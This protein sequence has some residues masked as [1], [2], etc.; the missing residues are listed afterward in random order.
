MRKRLLA[1]VLALAMATTL[2]P[3]SVF[4]VDAETDESPMHFTKTVTPIDR[5]DGKYTV[6]MEAYATGAVTTE[7]SSLPLD[8]VLVLDQSGSMSG[9]FKTETQSEY[10][11]IRNKNN[12]NYYWYA[13][14]GNLWYKDPSGQFIKVTVG[15]DTLFD[16]GHTK[17]TYSWDGQDPFVS[18][19]K[20][21]YP[22]QTFYYK[23]EQTIDISRLDA[24]KNAANAFVTSVAEKAKTDGVD[25]RIAVV[26]FAST[27]GWD[28]EYN[29]TE[30]LSTSGVV[31]YGSAIATDYKAALVSANDNGEVNV[32]LTTAISRLEADG[33][34]Y[35]EYGIDMANKIFAQYPAANGEQR[36]R[37]IVMFTDGYTAPYST[38]DIDYGMSDRAIK[39]ANDAK[40]IGAKVYTVGIFNGADPSRSITDGFKY[41]RLTAEEQLVAANRYMHY[42]SSNYVGVTGLKNDAERVENSN[43]YLAASNVTELNSVFSSISQQINSTT[44]T[45]DD[46]AVMKDVVADHFT[47]VDGGQGVTAYTV[48]FNGYKADDTPDWGTDTAAVTGVDVKGN[49]VSVSGFDYKDQFIRT[50]NGQNQGSKLVVEF[51]IE[52]K[53]DS[54]KGYLST[55]VGDEAGIYENAA[56]TDPAFTAE[57]SKQDIKPVAD[58]KGNDKTV[59]VGTQVNLLDSSK[60][61]FYDYTT[62]SSNGD[63]KTNAGVTIKYDIVQV[64]DSTGET[65]TPYGFRWSRDVQAGAALPDDFAANFTPTAPGDYFFKMT[66]TVTSTKPNVEEPLSATASKVVKLTAADSGTAKGTLIIAKTINWAGSEETTAAVRDAANGHTFTFQVMK[67]EEVA[68]TVDIT[69]NKNFASGDEMKV[70]SKSTQLPVGIYT[71]VEVADT[72]DLVDKDVMYKGAPR[73]TLGQSWPIKA[74]DTMLCPVSNVYN[75]TAP[76]TTGTLSIT[77]YV[78]DIHAQDQSEV[79]AAANGKIFSF[80]VTGANG[81]FLKNVVYS[82]QG[83]AKNSVEFTN[84]PAGEYTVTETNYPLVLGFN[85][86]TNLFKWS[87]AGTSYAPYNTSDFSYG[88]TYTVTVTADATTKLVCFNRYDSWKDGIGKSATNLDSNYISN[89]TL[90]LTGQEFEHEAEISSARVK[91]TYTEY[92]IPAGAQVKDFMGYTTDYNFDLVDISKMTVAVTDLDEDTNEI[93]TNTYPAVALTGYPQPETGENWQYGFNEVGDG[94]FAYYVKYQKASDGTEH[95]VWMTRDP[96]EE[97]TTVQINYSVK[98]MNPKTASGT[99]GQFDPYGEHDYA[100][101]LT[102][103]SAILYEENKW[104]AEGG[105]VTTTENLIATFPQPTVSYKISNNGGGGGGHSRPTLNTEDHYGYIIGY[106]DGTVQPGG[107]I[108]RAEVATIFF[109][110]LTDSSRTEFWSQTNSFSDVPST[111]WF[112]NAVS[113]LTKAGI[114]AGY[115]DGTFQP[116]ATITRAEFATIAV[117]FFEASYDGKDFFTDI[118]GHWAQ[119]YINDAANAGLVNGYED[120]TFGPNKAITRAEAMTLVNRALDRHPDA[121]HF[122]KDMITWPD[123][124][125]TTAWYYE[126]VQEATNSHEYTMKTNTDKT[127]YEN[128]TKMLK[129]R[130]WKAFE[131]AWSNANSASNPGE[132]MG[133]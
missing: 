93:K 66:V 113:T 133:K 50:E 124:S 56:A 77:K 30:L 88:S 67:G 130:D 4:A 110:M 99:Y 8:I 16:W 76:I 24:V 19:G 22:D 72:I 21:N 25:H 40:E 60:E 37:V 111:A 69:Y 90:T 127:K 44:V 81:S 116:N 35:S 128:W 2:L 71:V 102:N 118:D 109:R 38:D 9:L 100:G 32:R 86:D 119:Q 98:L 42:V 108:T 7:T 78:T 10:E 31:N 36:Q 105:T 97:G 34:T 95:F 63:Y 17:Y 68:A 14:R 87:Y 106:P 91:T 49:K 6:K 20:D 101:L 46:K 104:E 26:G 84:L 121:D 12:A 115:E 33:D 79:Q 126:A 1:C 65:E 125:D 62:P 53:K 82:N 51:T 131:A 83:S 13:A 15:K 41:G 59:P 114:I 64:T 120:G 48:P 39:N 85:K 52:L 18:R 122:L 92:S 117:R 45:L 94:Y 129:M 96:I 123:N 11:V 58:V 28:D 73:Y 112:N 47:I 23:N 75:E 132:V 61:S 80:T 74:N 55:N 29:N 43:Y 103:N 5:Q 27:K 107:S 70:N 89:V 3:M 57:V 54:L